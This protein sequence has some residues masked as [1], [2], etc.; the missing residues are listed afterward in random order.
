[1]SIG[2][3]SASIAAMP[4]STAFWSVTSKAATEAGAGERL[5]GAFQLG[6]VASVQHHMSARFRQ[7]LRERQA[8]AL[9]GTGDECDLAFETEQRQRH[10]VSS[11][12]VLGLGKFGLR[13]ACLPR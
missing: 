9:A 11:Q 1:M 8:D 4:A 2:P 6:L 3:I 7:P 5:A 13:K 12:S 10:G